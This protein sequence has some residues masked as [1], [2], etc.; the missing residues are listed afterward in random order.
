M[1][2]DDHDVDGSDE[3]ETSSSKWV[4]RKMLFRKL[5][6]I[7]FIIDWMLTGFAV[8]VRSGFLYIFVPVV[9]HVAL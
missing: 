2:V 8:F 1:N 6:R 4:A 7:G 5:I 3:R 9:V